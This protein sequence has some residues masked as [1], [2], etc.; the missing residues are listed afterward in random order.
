MTARVQGGHSTAWLKVPGGWILEHQGA[1]SHGTLY[2]V[3]PISSSSGV[4][5][6]SSGVS[7]EKADMADGIDSA[8]SAPRVYSRSAARSSPLLNEFDRSRTSTPESSNSVTER[9]VVENVLQQRG[10]R[11]PFSSTLDASDS[12]EVVEPLPSSATRGSFVQEQHSQVQPND[13]NNVERAIEDHLREL[14]HLL[15]QHAGGQYD[16][17]YEAVHQSSPRHR[18]HSAEENGPNQRLRQLATMQVHM[19]QVTR[20][21]AALSENVLHS[22]NALS[23]MIQGTALSFYIN[24]IPYN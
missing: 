6:N 7:G 12:E 8:S 22:H 16:D 24:I 3:V 2:S 19:E 14:R 13:N 5:G 10:M 23:R 21:L 20:N 18:K 1:I 11:A 9:P 15:A 17:L 4:E